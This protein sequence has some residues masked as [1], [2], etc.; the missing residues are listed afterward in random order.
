MSVD[1][2]KA[3]PMSPEEKKRLLAELLKKKAAAPKTYPAS[4]AQRRFWFLDQLEPGSPVYNI[5]TPMLLRGAYEPEAVERTVNEIVRRHESLRTV[6]RVVDDEPVQHVLPSL[7]LSVPFVDLTGLDDV[8]RFAELRRLSAASALAPF[9]LA[10]GP[11]LRATLVRIAPTDH[12]LMVCK[13]H[14]VA[15]G[16][17]NVIFEQ[18]FHGIHAAFARGEASPLPPLPLQYGDYAA[19]Q[20]QQIS[21]EALE[22]QLAWW[23][24]HLAGAPEVL[25]LPTDRPRPAVQ[26]Y[27]GA[28]AYNMVPPMALH[29]LNGLAQQEGATLFMTLLAAFQVLLFRYSGQEN[30]VVGTPIAGRLRPE[31]EPLIGVFVNTLVLHTDLSGN[32]T[33]REA[34]RRVRGMTLGAYGHQ[35]MPF[36]KL[37]DDLG[38]ERSLSHT[39][40]FQVLF[41]LSSV[42]QTTVARDAAPQDAGAEQQA[43]AFAGAVNENKPAMFDISLSASETPDGLLLELEYRRSL[44]EQ[45]TAMRM[46]YHL[47]R[48]LEMLAADPDQRIQEVPFLHPEE[49]HWAIV[50]FNNN[51]AE[52]AQTP[53]HAMV[54]AQVA[55]TPDAVALVHGGTRLTYAEVNARA[56]RLARHLAALGVG[57]ETR[58]GVS[59]ERTPEMAIAVL[60]VLK[61]GGCYV[62]MDPGYP[63]DRL[64]YMLESSAAPVLLTLSH[65]AD[66]LPHGG[67]TVVRLDGDR[68]AIDRHASDDLGVAVDLDNLAYVLYTS[69]S[70]GRPKGVALPQRALVNLLHW[71]AARWEGQPPA[72]T[73]QFASLSFDVSFQEIFSSWTTGGAVVLVDE[74]TRRDPEALLAHVRAHGVERLFLPFAALQHVAEVSDE[75]GVEGVRL[76]E[77]ITAGEQL[78]TTPALQRLARR[79]GAA[80]ENQYG[81]S[82][83]HVVSAFRLPDDVAEWPLLPPIGQPIANTQLYVLDGRMQPTPVG[84]HGEL[85]IAGDNLARGYLDRPG[86]TAERFLPNPFGP[87]GSRMY[88]TGD[89]VRALAVDAQLHFQGRIDHQVKVRGFRIELGEIEVLLQQHPSVK[90]S[91]VV[92]REDQPGDRRVVAYVSPNTGETIS[93][94]ALRAHLKAS[95]PD[96]MVP[97]AIVALDALPLSP[98]GKVDRKALPAP[99][100]ATEH[101]YVAPRTPTEAVLAGIWA[102]VL[103]VERVGATDS[104]FELGG[105]SLIATRVLS[106]IR[107][108]LEIELPVRVLFE[109]PTLAELAHR[110]DAAARGSTDGPPLVPVPRDRPLPLSFA[111]E[112]LW[113][114]DRLVP[115]SIAYNLPLILPVAGAD[116][117]VLART[118]AEIVHRHEALR[119]TFASVD[120]QVV[121]VIHPAGDFRFAVEDVV[122]MEG[123]T[124]AGALGRRVGEEIARPFDLER[125]PLFRGVLLRAEGADDVLVLAMHHVVS[126]GWSFNVLT[127]ELKAIYDAFAAGQPSPLPP[128]PVQYADFAA[129]QRQ[130]LTGD[131]LE[132]QLAYWRHALAGAPPVLALPLDRPRPPVETYRGAVQH[133][134]VSSR[135]A[136]A[137]REL[138]RREGATLFMT[139]LAGFDVLLSRWSGQDDVVVGSPIAGRNRAE[140][141]GLVGFFVNNLVLRTDL[142]GDPSFREAIGRVREVTLGAYAHQDLPFEK[143]VEELKVPRSLAHSP[144]FQVLFAL[145]NT[146]Q[147]AGGEGSESAPLPERAERPSKF[148]LSVEFNEVGDWLLGSIEY[149]VE[150][151]D[152]ATAAR[153]AAQLTALLEALVADP[154]APV[155]AHALVSPRERERLLALGRGPEPAYPREEDVAAVFARVAAATPDAV[156]VESADETL[157]YAQLEA[158]A[159]RLARHLHALGVRPGD[160]VALTADRSADLVVTLLAVAKAGGAYV[161]LDP[162]YPAERLAFMLEDS[163]AMLLVVADAVPASLAAF[164][165]PVVSLARDA[166][167]VAARD[168]SPFHVPVGGASPAY[169]VYTSG[170]T[171][172]PK[173][174]AV[175]HRGVLRLVQNAGFARMDAGETF[176]QFAPVAFDASTLEI[177]G[178]LLNGARLA[179]FPA[180]TP[181]LEELGAFVRDRGVTTLWLTAGLFHQMVDGP[182]EMLRGVRQLL[183]GGD[184]LSVEHCRRALEALPGTV[185]INGYGPTEATTF[186]ATHSITLA[187]TRRASVPIGRP[188]AHT[189]AR[190]LDARMQPV[191]VGVP[192]ELHIGGDG[193]AL[194]YHGR[195]E[196]TAS[197]FVAD[198]F[199]DDPDARLYKSGDRVRWL[200]D[201]TLEFL[202]R[203]DAQVKVRGFRIE[204][205][206][207][208]SAL[209]EL[210]G[211]RDAAVIVRDVAG[212]KRLAAYVVGD[213]VD[214]AEVKAALRTRLPDYMVPSSV[215]ALDAIPLTPNGK[216]DRRALPAPSEDGEGTA[217][218]APR[219]GMET[220]LAEIWREVLGR[221]RVGAEDDFFDLGG[222]S[223]LATRVV[224]RIREAFGAEL[225]LRALFEAPTVAALAARIDAAAKGDAAPAIV[226]VP[227]DEPLPLSFAQ[228]RLWFFDRLVP[229]SSVYNVPVV[230][231]VAG[232]DAAVMERVLTEV[233]RRHESLRTTFAEHE[234]RPVQ[235]IRPA[236]PVSLARIDLSHL[237]EGERAAEAQRIIGEESNRPFDL[238]EGPLFRAALVEAGEA[239][240]LV[241]V[242]HH[243]VSDGWSMDVLQREIEALY[244]AFAAGRPSP[245]PE[246]ALQYADF[247][248]W[249]RAHL[250]GDV[251]EGQLAF[252]KRHLEGAPALLDLPT[253]RPRPA[254]QTFVGAT[255]TVRVGRRAG[256]ALAAVAREEGATPFMALLAAFSV[257][258]SRYA[259]QDDVVV[260]SPIAGR[261]RTEIEG[262]IGFFVNSL[263]L[264]TDVSGD[265]TFRQLLAQVRETTL[266]AYAH[267][268]V[269]FEK[270]VE[271]LRVERSL[272]HSPLFQV[273]FALQNTA[274]SPSTDGEMPEG[275]EGDEDGADAVGGLSAAKFD[276]SVSLT[277]AGGGFAG[278]IEYNT[279]LFDAATVRRLGRHF[280]ALVE[281]AATRPDVPLSHLSMLGEAERTTVVETWNATDAPLP[282]EETVH[283]ALEAVARRRADAVA[284][285]FEGT[286]I[287]YGELNARANRLAHR[288]R[289]LGVGRD[290]P[291]AISVERGPDM[292]VA[293]LGA[294]KAG[295]AYLPVDPA[296]PRDRR[297]YML[298]DSGAPVLLTQSALVADLPEHAARVVLL[299][300]AEDAGLIARESDGDPSPLSGG[301]DLAYVIYTSGSTGRPKG[302]MVPHRG[303]VNLAAAQRRAFAIDEESRLL[304]FASFSFDAAAADVVQALLTGARLHLAPQERLMPGPDFVRLIDGERISVATLP[305]SVLSALGDAALPT[306]RTLASAGE[307][308]GP[309]IV[310]RWAP[311][312]RFLNAYGP[313]ET[314]VC[315]TIAE[316]EDGTRRPSIGRP[317]DNLRVYVVDA[318]LRPLP[319]GVPGEIC[320]GGIGVARG[321]LRRPG[322]TAEKFVAD[323]FS[324]VPG[325]RMYR[326]GDRG[327]WLADGTIDYL[328]RIDEQVKVRGFRIEPGEIEAVLE[329]APSV[330]DAVVVVRTD[331][332]DR[333]IVAYVVPGSGETVDAPALK[334]HAASRLPDYMVPAAVVAIDAVPLTPNGK[335]DRKA[336]PAPE[337]EATEAYVAPRTDTERALAAVW[338]ELLGRETVGIHDDFFALGGHSLSATR[339]VSRV[340]DTMRVEVPL[341]VLF[342]RPTV[343][344]FA[345][346]LTSSVADG[347]DAGRPAAP[348]LVPVER[349]GPV[350]MSFAQER[351]WFVDRLVPGS[352]AYNVPVVLPVPGADASVLE[353]ALGEI[354]ARHEAL[355]TTFAE[356]EGTPVQVIHPA[357]PFHLSVI[358]LSALPQAEREAAMGAAV[359]EETEAPF[360]LTAGPLFRARLVR[361]GESGDLL[362]VTMHHVVSDGWSVGVLT[363]ELTALYDAFSRGE[364]SPLAPLPVQYADYAAW[365]RAWLAGAELERQAAWWAGQL[366]GAPP[367][368][369]LPTDRPRPAVQTYAGAVR[370]IVLPRALTASLDAVA[371]SEGATPFMAMLAGVSA[372]LGRWAGTDDVIVGSP[373]AGR[374]RGETEGLIGFFVN[375]LVLRTDLSGAPAFR[376]L[377]RRAKETTLGAYAHQ[378]LPFERLVE[379]LKVE[380][381]LAHTPVFQVLF[382]WLTAETGAAAAPVDGAG[383]MD[384]GLQAAKYDL[385]LGVQEADGALVVSLNHNTDLFDGATASR[386]LGHLRTLLEAAAA[387]PDAPLAELS[388]LAGDER[389]LVLETFN[390]TGRAYP[391]DL[392]I[393]QLFETRAAE[394]PEAVALSFDGERIT[395]RQ[396]NGLANRLAHHL[397]ALGVGPETLVGVC[398]ERTPDL[399][400]SLLAVLKAGG[401]YVPLDPAYPAARIALMVEDAGAAVVLTQARLAATLPETAAAVVA[402]DEE[403]ALLTAPADDPAPVGTDGNT[404]Y[405]IF[406]SGSTGRPKG[407]QIEHRSV[408]AFLHWF[409]EE[410]T[411][412]ELGGM[413]GS[414]SVSFDVSVAEIFGTLCWGG[415][416]VLVENALSLA[417]VGDEDVRVATMVPSA[418]AELARMG[419]V[420]ASVR[421]FNLAG[422]ALPPTVAEALHALPSVETVRNLYGPTEDTT[423][424]TVARVP[425]GGGKVRIGRPIANSQAFVLDARLEPVPVG[426]PGELYLAGAGLTRGYLSRP[427]LTAERWVPNPHGPAGSR[428]YRVG[429]VAR[430]LPDGELE[431][432]GRTD[433]QVKVRG[434]RIETGEIETALL[435]HPAV[436]EAAVVARE[437]AAGDTRLVAYVSPAQGETADGAALR[438]HL[439][440]TLP[441]Y[442]VPA[443]VVV[444]DALPQTPNGKLDRRALPAP[445]L[446]DDAG[447]RAPRTPAEEAMA[448][449]WADVL[450]VE[451]VGV[452]RN[453]FDLGGHSLLATRVV[454]RVRETFGVELPLRALF[455]APTVAELAARVAAASGA[456]AAPPVLPA[457]RDGPVR[458]SFAQERL[459]F[460]ERL[461]P[462]TSTYNIPHVLPVSGVD[463]DVLRRALTAL[464][465]RHEALRTTFAEVDGE[466]VQI[467]HPAGEFDLSIVDLSH[468]PEGA[469]DAEA[470]A[471]IAAEAATPFDLVAGPLFRATLVRG[472]DEAQ[473]IVLVMHHA[474]SDGWS[475]DVLTRELTALYGAFARGEEP[476]LAPLPVQYADYALWQRAWLQGDVLARQV[477]YWRERLDGAPALLDLP[478]DRPRPAVQGF[479]GASLPVRLPRETSDAVAALARQA[480]VTPFMALLAAF[481]AVLGRWAGTDDIVVGSPI[482]GRTRGETEGL[483]GFF[484]N[485]L[486]LRT[487]LSGDPS[488]RALLA[489]V[490]EVTL[491]AYAHQD[492]PFEKLVEELRVERSLAHTPLFQV[493]FALQTTGTP[494]T[495]AAAPAGGGDAGEEDAPA[496]GTTSKFD[497]TL[498]LSET[499]DGLAGALE[500]ATDLF[501]EA[502]ARR[503]ARHFRALVTA[504][505]A[506]PDAPVSHLP[507]AGGDE[508]AALAA[509]NDTAR[510]FPAAT[511]VHALFAARAAE[512]PD[513]PAVE[514]GGETMTYGELDARSGRLARVLAARG[515][516]PGD[517][518]G[519]SLAR[520]AD[521]V[522]T[523]LAILKAGGAYVP[524]D[525][526]YPATRLAHMLADAD[527]SLLV[528]D[529]DVP[530]ALAGFGGTVVSLASVDLS[531]DVA[532]LSVETDGEAAAY[533]L[534]TSGSTGLP[535][536]VAVPH[537]AIARL[538]VG[539]DFL[540]FGPGETFLQLAPVAFDA[541]TLEIW[542]ALLNG[543][544]LV[545]HPPET[546]TL[547][548]LG[549][550]VRDRGVTTLWLTAGLFHQM[551]DGPIETLRGVRH[552]LAGGDALSVDHCRRALEALPGTVLLNG[553]GPTETTTFATT[554]RISVSDTA[555]ASIPI[556]RPIANTTAHVLDAGMRPAPVGVP[557]ELYVGGPGVALGYLNQPALTAERFGADPFSAD[558]SARLYRTGDRVRRLADGTLEF[559]GRMDA[560]VKLRGFRIEPGEIEAA[561]RAH[562]A[563]RDA[564]VV[565]RAD[566]GEKRLAAYVVADGEAPSAAALRDHLRGSL[567]DYMVPAAFVSLDAI[568]L[569]PN[570]KVD[571]RALPA[572]EVQG[573]AYVAPR[574]E[575]EA[576]LAEMWRELL[577]AERVG[578]D[579]GFFDLGGHSLVATRL[580]SRIRARF[581]VE[582]PL[583]AVFEATTVATLA[584]RVDAAVAEGA[585]D[586]GAAVPP[587]V[588]VQRDGPVPMSFAQERLWFVDRLV[589]S[590]ATYN[591]P[592]ILPVGAADGAVL[593]RA[594]GALLARHEA[595]RTTFASVDGQPVQVIHP[596]SPFHLPVTDARHLPFDERVE[597]EG[598]VI[599]EVTQAPFDL[600]EG[601]LFRARFLRMADDYAFL[602]MAMHHVV[603]DGWSLGVLTRELTALYD[604]F[605]QGQDSPLAPLPVQYADYAAWQRAWLAGGELERQVG[606]WKERLAGAPPVLGL[607]TDRPRPAVQTFGGRAQ[608]RVLDEAVTKRLHA[609]A[610]AEGATPFMVTLAAFSLLLGRWAAT[611]DVVVGSPVAGRTRAE[612]EGL[613]GFFVNNLVMRTDLSGAPTFRDLVRRA[614][615]TTLGAYAHQDM[616][617]EKL[618]EELKVER[619]LS[620]TPVFQVLFNWLTAESGADTTLAAE[621]QV[622]VEPAK[623]D[624]S[625]GAKDAGGVLQLGMNYNADLFDDATIGRMLGHLHRLL[626]EA[627]AAPDAPVAEISLLDGDERRLVLETFNDTARPYPADLRIHQLFEARVAERPDAVALVHGGE[628][629]T[630]R[631]LNARANR[632]AHHL[633]GLGVG[634]ESLVGVCMER[635]PD[636]VVSLLAVLKAGGGYVPLDPAYPAERI[637]MMLEDAHA[638]VVLT[639]AKLA[640]TLPETAA[641]VVSV[642]GDP[643]LLSRPETDLPAEGTDGSTA[644]VIFT[645]GSTG[646]PKGVQIEHRSVVAFLHWFRE[647]MSDEELGGMLGATSVSFDVSVAEIFGTLCWGG[648]LVLVEN[649][650]SLP[651]VAGEDVRVATMVP[652]A[653]AELVRMGGIPAS[654]RAFN[655]GGEALPSALAEALHALP[656]VETVRNL[657]GPTE[658]TTYSTFAHVPAGGGKVRIGRP[659]AN[660]QALVLDERLQPVP[661]GVPGELYLA[662]QGLTRGYL[663]RPS[664]T[665]ERW[666]PNPHGPAGS[667]MYRVGD[668]VRWLPDGE[669]EYLGRTDHQV[670]VRGFRIETGEI[671]AALRRHPAVADAVTVAREIVPGDTR[672]IAYLVA[673]AGETLDGNDLRNHLRAGLPDYMVPAA[674]VLLEALPL[675]PNGKVDRRALPLPE[676]VADGGGYVAPR[677]EVEAELAALWAEVLGVPRVGIH[678]DFFALGGH[679]L[680]AVRMMSGV[681]ARFGRELPLTALFQGATVEQLA[682]LLRG[683]GE[684]AA[685][686][687][688]VPVQPQGSRP[689]FFLVH[690]IAG[691]VLR[692][693]ALGRALAPDQPFYALRSLGSEAGEE[694][695]GTVEEMAAAYVEAIRGVQPSGPYYL[696]GWSGGCAIAFEAAQQLVAAGEEVAALVLMDGRAPTPGAEQE[697]HDEVYLLSWLVRELG[698]PAPDHDAFTDEMEALEGEERM[699]RV[700]RWINA[701]GTLLPEGDTSTLRRYLAV[702]RA[703][704][705]ATG[706]YRPKLYRGKMVVLQARERMVQERDMA[707]SYGFEVDEN[708]VPGWRNLSVGGL[709]SAIVP[710]DHYGMLSDPS[711]AEVAARVRKV[712][713]PAQ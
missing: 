293:L 299:D 349:H 465:A 194:G 449:L 211:M 25:E 535:K 267:Q 530:E 79:T 82:E 277:E 38:V 673:K 331:G 209:R 678:D 114:V 471:R 656:T 291:V 285:S 440:A 443:A 498:N 480:G 392:R 150:L 426:V 104:F 157:T 284:V 390:D 185:L 647:E 348:P 386:M 541:S 448:A 606:W 605:A 638:P 599:A 156:A 663:N 167:A 400:V 127:T 8:A 128:L 92:V 543:A 422:E 51:A 96:Y 7:H 587:L 500:F 395:Y 675:T 26:D 401:G 99:D 263:V 24:Q 433:H 409:R 681:K 69:G 585:G 278:S 491:G 709:S 613:I 388:L 505:V 168:G 252:W 370:S 129:W 518:V 486:V 406:T 705:H 290:V 644:Y 93:A 683:G 563:V 333:R 695:L 531:A 95:L 35:E 53:L 598:R 494:S 109:A 504:A 427:S 575:T 497:L 302:V 642:D 361:G 186:A 58:V 594:L 115:G 201:G 340:R 230:T 68:E 20:R 556:G 393:H 509:W 254:V 60:A 708:Y 235:V 360:D 710:G 14:I 538:V 120:G 47:G 181:T 416:L 583:R 287:T 670:K 33:F 469:R 312:R 679:S 21:G 559:M 671:D 372:L 247:A 487:D 579:D 182:I 338:A 162:T 540:P 436:A 97:S 492:V 149:S 560:Q 537:R 674:F 490:R 376:D 327:R 665:A 124:G 43:G 257:L 453:F 368:L 22:A 178:A 658:D 672:L 377:V 553:Y 659:I 136:H 72:V 414:T 592:L 84:V 303:V 600:T 17:S 637:G 27:D 702:L 629:V 204:L 175:P 112:R 493:M 515:V 261:G 31:V 179:V 294:M 402:V 523:L 193:L 143:L 584:V 607:P 313:T 308:L 238:T 618:V 514:F 316:G 623:F 347:G 424:S 330:A 385:T 100:G 279:D 496:T 657:Y 687:P 692:Y 255:Q 117:A 668:V 662:G 691:T 152:D 28:T 411:D 212:D 620:H 688:L 245:L 265:P 119:T 572:P 192:G 142:S 111:Q 220:A 191:P 314:T 381:S 547:E 326:T 601:P 288:L 54:E 525:A 499:P 121:Q 664:L 369:Q 651:E 582:L 682:A 39:P 241:L 374:T 519:L 391:A 476:D 507:L 403:P 173:G 19:W 197:T 300:G 217:Y 539:N 533:V 649:A 442:M 134:R 513:A 318:A 269:P 405:V 219:E 628:R 713:E 397:R 154:D 309:E 9:D 283:A 571:R 164:A 233:V 188:I 29:A 321:Y 250:S 425:A 101:R 352:T 485:N 398:M 122:P 551:V 133:F 203:I 521:L 371:R 342:E 46:A 207:I 350:P 694:P 259:G 431:Y 141:E 13:H 116:A 380:R 669:L 55:R 407:V 549:A 239:Q 106:R 569:T 332:G 171:G 383:E 336:L 215:T 244:G 630:Y 189:T 641:R 358:D 12:V 564:A 516:H 66:R 635:T 554:H 365:Q 404:A 268:D 174:V 10:E 11:L 495:V 295:G 1:T 636:L 428:M 566:G 324:S 198:P 639:Q 412:D 394:Q 387:R 304:Q 256:E 627:T 512:T 408:V 210:P 83:S 565:V 690:G 542:G 511:P 652:S 16:W 334:Q 231:P 389:R 98:N 40:L 430:W 366:A 699:L 689:P 205:G 461:V 479:A 59:V 32:P 322:L 151:F 413:L 508:R 356:I 242:M 528:V 591:V 91:V 654:V 437:A 183:A 420:P 227:R 536:G 281:A 353:R 169:V 375:N 63:A 456:E 438:A 677:D 611:D 701:E 344:A 48:L 633:R 130:Y 373:V 597:E 343:A 610:A 632:V 704:L 626:A 315:A 534:Y 439:R 667:R 270:L 595:L 354:V 86:L 123:E 262:M 234:G 222:H 243:I 260:G 581:G 624:L 275:D 253:D 680:L 524:L 158:R 298:A 339:L 140:T 590:G 155:S 240:A 108:A 415:R 52:Y 544:R 229:G 616:P 81:P 4:F 271:E 573:A 6:F 660:T 311:G 37:V 310:R 41:A 75:V 570:G 614:K 170:S 61:A 90:E 218:V 258:L 548:A 357:S 113:F 146:T 346:Y 56:N 561:L 177:W 462:G 306:L 625:L 18:E 110:V 619:S 684:T 296:Y 23:R 335:V 328:G 226:P 199:S 148:D 501:D 666:V 527:V 228:E 503:L 567:P 506:S 686:T 464:V 502:T 301:D 276:L 488:F 187:D 80:L 118:V 410:M 237:P 161:P 102:E 378:D 653:A 481:S 459:W 477:A 131:V 474:V 305:P 264:R 214:S 266:G 320:V 44:W 712:T 489:R 138:A 74:D 545:V 206:E 70:T 364:A 555:R 319:I 707:L 457:H 697:E 522:V 221:E 578:V 615:E 468:L 423:Y 355:R 552:L 451:R 703:N 184:A 73:L 557:G 417:S 139:L 593:E 367:V 435:R 693:A 224:S 617:F 42:L 631:A 137:L 126:D 379:E 520:S 88:R 562:P 359:A 550:L 446:A 596:A 65:L 622:S 144:L 580:A 676:I 57:P 419:G 706:N 696:G 107:Q 362:A 3:A 64:A 50:R 698:R 36:D 458:M 646:R 463:A 282:A 202:G 34:V 71:Q 472:G 452:D 445:E 195:P 640:R 274:A 225:P 345:S 475:L 484:V 200:E 213:A 568:P 478:A 297:A 351:L 272:A 216:V 434:F 588:P 87:A 78:R 447:H 76:R 89:R 147:Y 444:L 248:V 132:A 482:A 329:T 160:R 363:R 546:P 382:N 529:G 94:D 249:Q 153:M 172:R 135:L 432:L 307:A 454:S 166:A 483:I 341:R 418:A 125:G 396:L 650:L 467:V 103:K 510:P 190:V 232:V 196:L 165:G 176:L 280:A 450:G 609:L 145:Q 634:P 15:D 574:T 648:R 429:D 603:S 576:A 517:R 323:P 604:A 163:G 236:A 384:G 612:T 223:L 645:S 685:T 67:A 421:T 77:I 45:E 441:D 473:A 325:A 526:A 577:G 105:H 251:L 180:G 608:S 159:S 661:V 286:E 586:A 2:G 602:V 621:G 460:V 49:R 589:E 399:I 62:A 317:I 643:A 5:E 711:V 655:L 208:E 700:L 466:P 455:E 292:V 30:V 558:A 337:M 273:M 289:A 246:P 532:P 85:Y 470:A